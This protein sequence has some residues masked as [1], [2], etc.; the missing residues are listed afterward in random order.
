[1]NIDQN[2]PSVKEITAI[3]LASFL[4]VLIG[5]QLILDFF[6]KWNLVIL[7]LLTIAPAFLW[8]YLKKWPFFETFRIK[9]I[10]WTVAGLSAIIGLG[11][12]TVVDELDR[13]I[14]LIL[15]MDERLIDALEQTVTYQ[16][17]SEFVPLFLAA[18]ILAAII[19]EMLF[20][21][22][23]LKALESKIDVTN[24]VIISAL[25]FTVIHMNPW[26]A[27]QIL[28]LGVILGVLSWRT[29][30]IVPGIIVHGVNN[31][32]SL[33]MMN[34]EVEKFSWYEMQGHVAPVWIF[35]GLVFLVGGFHLFYL[36][37]EKKY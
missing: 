18:V 17:M 6:G 7:E 8:A 9:K 21:G 24:A 12:A 22:I 26:W 34:Q 33:I 28:I 20:R 13:L 25:L 4:L 23:L 19:E 31:M 32:L 36:K 1:M 11:I 35:V 10:S 37:T 15:P 5:S 29:Q 2:S 3:F 27:V 16:S 30:S 14:Q